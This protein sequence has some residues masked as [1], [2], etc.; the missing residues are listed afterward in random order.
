MITIEK[1]RKGGITFKVITNT[2][3]SPARTPLLC[4]H[5]FEKLT[6][7]SCSGIAMPEEVIERLKLYLKDRLLNCQ[8]KG[9]NGKNKDGKK[10]RKR[11]RSDERHVTQRPEEEPIQDFI[12]R[13][14]EVVSEISTTPQSEIN[15]NVGSIFESGGRGDNIE[16]FA[17]RHNLDAKQPI[18]I[19]FSVCNVTGEM[20]LC[21]DDEND[22]RLLDLLHKK[23]H[24]LPEA[25]RGGAK[26]KARGR[27]GVSARS[28]G[29]TKVW[30]PKNYATPVYRNQVGAI[31]QNVQ[32]SKNL[33][34]QFTRKLCQVGASCVQLSNFY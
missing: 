28:C 33:K 1:P 2:S 20:S 34:D 30:V 23:L 5:P 7:S 25:L 26:A 14:M 16:E 24:P 10:K 31:G 32:V 21:M 22:R 19:H 4:D 3:T 29:A 12:I 6:R 13:P 8:P 17:Q 18:P 27:V 11:R 15:E 9:K